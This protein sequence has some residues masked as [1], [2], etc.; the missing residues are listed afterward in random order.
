MAA[1]VPWLSEDLLSMSKSLY[2]HNNL[3]QQYLM[4][5]LSQLGLLGAHLSQSHRGTISTIE[6][7]GIGLWL[8]HTKNEKLNVLLVLYWS[9]V[10]IIV[11]VLVTMVYKL[12]TKDNSSAF[13]LRTYRVAIWT[14]YI[15]LQY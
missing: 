9:F 14:C 3:G 13:G 10:V 6:H 7:K 5:V 12:L 1:A 8:R 2:Y 15:L 4:S 11:T